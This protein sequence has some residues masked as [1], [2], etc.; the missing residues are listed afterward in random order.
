M[1]ANDTQKLSK[2]CPSILVVDDDARL[3]SLLLKYLQENNFEVF[4]VNSALQAKEIIKLLEFNLIVLDIMM[5]GETGI[6][7][8]QSI[9]P[10]L[11]TP[12]L[13]LSAKYEVDDRIR[14]LEVGA[15]DYLA[16]P[17]EPK[18]LILRIHAILKRNSPKTHDEIL[19]NF[20]P[21]TYNIQSKTLQKSGVVLPL[22]LV[23]SQLLECFLAHEGQTLSREYLCAVVG[24]SALNHR[25][26][27]VQVTR[28]R[29]KIENNPKQPNYILT[30]RNSGYVFWRQHA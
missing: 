8:L 18:E 23:E 17:F 21:W 24:E 22:S 20:G 9:K 10:G 6:E 25:S 2:S 29:R 30:V 4:A 14:G 3:R 11:T 7:L 5:P 12:V 19:Q 26:V 16:K 1:P 28:L 27:D 13:V 15:D